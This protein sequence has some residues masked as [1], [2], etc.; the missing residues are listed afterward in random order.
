MNYCAVCTVVVAPARVTQYR[1]QL[2]AE[3]VLV[4]HARSILGWY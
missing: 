4:P 1:M 2:E 3:F